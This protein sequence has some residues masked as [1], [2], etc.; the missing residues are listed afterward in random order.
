MQQQTSFALYEDCA[1]ALRDAV[2]VLGGTKNVG[3]RLRPDMAPDHAGAWLKDCLNPERREKLDLTQIFHI[4][5]WAREENHHAPMLYIASEIGYD[6]R[7]IEP[8]NELADAQRAFMDSVAQQK[9]IIDRIERL[10]RSPFQ[11]V[12]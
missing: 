8:K 6:A 10:T 11:A 1:D 5:R 9:L 12:K 4:L 2:R 7:P 3:H